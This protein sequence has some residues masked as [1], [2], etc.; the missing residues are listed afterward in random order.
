MTDIDTPRGKERPHPR[1]RPSAAGQRARRADGGIRT[2]VPALHGR[3]GYQ[4]PAEAGP[5]PN[6]VRGED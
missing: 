6:I 5:E 1:P 2:C 3:S 4:E